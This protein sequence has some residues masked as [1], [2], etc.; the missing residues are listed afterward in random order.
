[1]SASRAR[2]GHFVRQGS[3]D[4]AFRALIPAPLPPDPPLAIDAELLLLLER[5][6][7][8]LG[9]LD[10]I[11]R[12]LP[13]PELFLFGYVRKEAVLS[14]Q[15]E[16][17]Q[18]S[19]S[20]LL[21]F[22]NESAPSVPEGDVKEVSNYVAALEHGLDLLRTKLPLSLRLLRQVHDVLVSGTRGGDKTPGEFRTSQNWIG[23][24]RPGNAAFVPPPPHELGQCLTNLERFLNDEPTRTPAVLK[25]GVAHAQFETI[26]PFLDGNGRVGRL[27][28]T[29][30]LV[31]EGVLK[32]PLLYV[33]LFFKQHRDEYYRRLQAVR[34]DGDWEG[35]IRFYVEGVATVAEQATDTASRL[36][37]LF[38]RD[39]QK[40]SA[41][42]R[43]TR[44][45]HAALELVMRQAIVS[46]PEITKKLDATAPTAAKAVQELERL[47][48]I[49]EITGK[50]RDRR[51]V[52]SDYVNL[53]TEGTDKPL[54]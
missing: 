54:R 30:V 43:S 41:S 29:L 32:E 44:N 25:A 6:G 9:R 40:V 51:F 11:A 52:Y 31:A 12:L 26:H 7:V 22:E 15:I 36:V 20:D 24:S 34:T 49:R 4:A 3:G 48:I 28:I 17:T 50:Q 35:W 8:A 18:S 21:L 53:L 33:S 46:I 42:K 1:M 16:G 13:D 37:A 39:R 14:S 2:A 45:T 10:G 38:E 23:G 5:A 27:L 47:G 19:L